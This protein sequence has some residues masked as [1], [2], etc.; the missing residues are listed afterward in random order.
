MAIFISHY[1]LQIHMKD[2]FSKYTWKND[3]LL[4]R[5]SVRLAFL[6]TKYQNRFIH[7]IAIGI[8][9]STNWYPQIQNLTFFH[10]GTII[11]FFQICIF[12]LIV[13]RYKIRPIFLC[14]NILVQD[15]LYIPCDIFI[16][17]SPRLW[18]SPSSFL[19][20]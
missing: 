15:L 2:K 19:L 11:N 6:G 7:S 4:F 20:V 10:W 14:I 18:S 13:V 5:F 12:C 8:F 9:C 17:N 1:D 16:F 3:K